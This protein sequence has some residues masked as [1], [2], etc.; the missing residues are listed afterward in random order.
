[1]SES[2][3]SHACS[4]QHKRATTCYMA[5]PALVQIRSQSMEDGEMLLMGAV[6]QPCDWL[7]A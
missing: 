6:P 4:E 2:I 7:R 1:M 5:P 3:R